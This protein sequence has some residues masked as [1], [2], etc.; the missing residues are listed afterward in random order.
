MVIRALIY[1]DPKS[2]SLSY[3]ELPRQLL[4]VTH[5]HVWPPDSHTPSIHLSPALAY[6]FATLVR[7]DDPLA[8]VGESVHQLG[9]SSGRHEAISDVG[10]LGRDRCCQIHALQIVV[11]T[12]KACANVEHLG[13]C[14][15]HFRHT[16][17]SNV[18]KQSGFLVYDIL[19]ATQS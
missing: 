17:N 11:S 10:A 1:S 2:L 14:Q 12:G 13:I 8:S 18:F 9:H 3:I 4:V 5:N 16:G 15:N 7:G 6:L 19:G